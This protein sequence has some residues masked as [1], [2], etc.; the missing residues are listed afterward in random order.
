[1]R[2][3]AFLSYKSLWEI[4][5]KMALGKLDILLTMRHLWTVVEESGYEIL[6]LTE[7]DLDTLSELPYHHGDPF[8]R[9]IIAQA[10]QRKLD[11]IS[12]HKNFTFHPIQLP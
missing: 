11:V 10:L 2:N 4:T 6:Y 7:K 1:M 9:M 8:D 12:Y 5:I 3:T